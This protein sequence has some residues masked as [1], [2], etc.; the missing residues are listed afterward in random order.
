VS[1]GAETHSFEGFEF[2]LPI[3]IR[4]H[5]NIRSNAQPSVR[6][7]EADPDIPVVIGL[8]SRRISA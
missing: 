1:A 8:K 7:C 5:G 2:G 6:A 3:A 4:F